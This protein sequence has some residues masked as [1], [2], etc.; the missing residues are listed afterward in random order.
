[1]RSAD[2]SVNTPPVSTAASAD[3][4]V[5][6]G[7]RQGIVFYL[8]SR[9]F[10]GIAAITLFVPMI[11]MPFYER[12]VGDL[13]EGQAGTFVG[14]LLAATGE[15]LYYEDYP[16]V[17]EYTQRVIRSTR[18]IRKATIRKRGEAAIEVT[19]DGWRLLDAPGSAHS[20]REP[21]PGALEFVMPLVLRDLDWGEVR[22]ELSQDQRDELMREYYFNYI[23]F[24]LLLIIGV[25]VLMYSS[26][27]P[28][29]R[30]LNTLHQST[31][32]IARGDLAVRTEAEGI[33]ELGLLSE[34]FNSMAEALQAQSLRIGQ[35]ADVVEESPS[36]VVIYDAQAQEVFANRTIEAMFAELGQPRPRHLDGLLG[37]FDGESQRSLL[38][39]KATQDTF[40]VD[41]T[42]RYSEPTVFV[43]LSLQ[44]L[45][46][47]HGDASYQVLIAD[48]ITWRKK[49][50]ARLKELAHFDKLTR[51]P[52]RREFLRSLD[53]AFENAERFTVL[54]LDLDNFKVINDSLGH[55]A[56]DEVLAT[57]AKRL[58]HALREDDLVARLGGDEFTAIL[59]NV[60][61]EDVIAGTCERL[62]ASLQAPIHFKN[63]RLHVGASIGAVRVPGEADSPTEVLRHADIAMYHAK[64]SGKGRHSLFE[65]HMLVAALS[66]IETEEALRKAVDQD[67]LTVHFQPIVSTAGELRALEALVRWPDSGLRPD[68]F[69]G[70]AEESDLILALDR[71]VL[72][73]VLQQ[74]S[75][76]GLPERDIRV[77]INLSGRTVQ[78]AHLCSWVE[79]LITEMDI[80]PCYI[81]LE[82]T[83]N[84][85]IDP[86]HRSQVEQNL[87]YLRELGCRIALDDFGRGYSSFSYLFDFDIDLI[88]FDRSFVVRCLENP[89]A[90]AI[91]KVILD[92]ANSLGIE[93]VAEGVETTEQ[94]EWLTERGCHRL[95]GHLFSRPLAAP[96]IA[97]RWLSITQRRPSSNTGSG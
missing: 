85:L 2:E 89:K 13:M 52:N 37:C 93:T 71:W 68:Q 12:R 42:L 5:P 66:R 76:W 64:R 45:Q 32:R 84:V 60:D 51:L 55:E 54:F 9:I 1:M 88:K 24:S 29:V 61:S 94:A 59:R 73:R 16:A 77:S 18:G 53:V 33:G 63:H 80:D 6:N 15:S 48:N 49:L 27:R 38:A 35:L 10:F 81:Q 91:V 69:I 44:T 11:Y 20:A 83:E 62:T 79:V 57:A 70:I 14:N 36:G 47:Q 46:R 3:D 96:E 7:R 8:F 26:S 23:V 41:A 50:E 78:N 21:M 25:L 30:Q 86:N 75:R 95:Q 72:R 87:S 34:S 92:M 97:E 28:I 74:A 67:E 90:A 65:H 39:L 31:L 56:G 82:I 22:L 40:S 58:Q 17:I 43:G 19:R 4:A